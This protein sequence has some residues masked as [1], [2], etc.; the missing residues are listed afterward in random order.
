MKNTG[1]E[2]GGLLVVMGREEKKREERKRGRKC[3]RRERER[4]ERGAR[5]DD[6]VI[7]SWDCGEKKREI[8]RC[9]MI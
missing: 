6:E 9:G 1:G 7:N 2:K 5:Q 4:W 8:K 3:L